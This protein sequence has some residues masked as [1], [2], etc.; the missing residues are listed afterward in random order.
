LK[1]NSEGLVVSARW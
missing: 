1:L